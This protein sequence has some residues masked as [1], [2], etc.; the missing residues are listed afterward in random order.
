MSIDNFDKYDELYA[1]VEAGQSVVS[2]TPQPRKSHSISEL[3]IFVGLNV[4]MMPG[5]AICYLSIGAEGLR[6]LMGV[7]STRLS[8]LPI[9]FAEYLQDYSGFEKLDLA[10]LAA[11]ILFVAMTLLWI[12]IFKELQD[13]G[14]VLLRRSS[15]PILFFVVATIAFVAVAADCYIFY[16]GLTSQSASAWGESPDS[17]PVIVSILYMCGLAGIGAWHADFHYGRRV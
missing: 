7:F 1:S 3:T 6:K 10:M 4:I 17:V 8:K 16:L 9:P 12:R 13:I 15:N 14:S 2:D 5:L 11:I